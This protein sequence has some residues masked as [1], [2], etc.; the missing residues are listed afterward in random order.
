MPDA[1]GPIPP[2]AVAVLEAKPVATVASALYALAALLEDGSV[3]AWGWEDGGGLIPAATA[4]LLARR[5][6]SLPRRR[7]R[8]SRLYSR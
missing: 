8:R 7:A 5:C 2:A 1:G 4:P 6:W 3:Q